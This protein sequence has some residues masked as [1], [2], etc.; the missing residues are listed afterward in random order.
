MRNIQFHKIKKRFSEFFYIIKKQLVG[1]KDNFIDKGHEKL[2]IMFI[3]HNEKKIFDF[4]ISKFIVS[5][6]LI[7]FVVVLLTSSYA[8]IKNAKV[9]NEEERLLSDYKD[10]R[11]HLLKCEKLTCDVSLLLNEITPDI[12]DLYGLATGED[13]FEDILKDYDSKGIA[14][15]KPEKQNILL[16]KEIFQ[17]R[18]LQHDF[19]NLT[20]VVKTLK[21]FIA[22]RTQVINDTPSI[23]PNRGHI[24]SLFGWRRSPFGFGRDFHTGIDIAAPPGVPIRSTAPGVV[25]SAGWGGGYGFMVKIRHKYG[26]QTIYGH[27][28][29]INVKPG[30]RVKKGQII[31][32]VGQTGSATGN[33]CHYEIRV[34]KSAINPYPYMSK[35]W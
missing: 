12:N 27:C 9:K 20:N 8:I 3:P 25:I 23:I 1:L 4:Q 32:Y 21:N 24:S 29:R 13:D 28:L 16:P 22:V 6:F 35:L 7:L 17:L 34:G 11:S 14:S 26:F 19:I 15:S 2:T 5:F 33:H 31:S 10:I 30:E 18:D